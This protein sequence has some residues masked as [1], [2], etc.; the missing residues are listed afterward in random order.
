VTGARLIVS[1]QIAYRGTQALPS[2]GRG[3]V[4]LVTGVI[5]FVQDSGNTRQNK[6]E[7]SL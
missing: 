7:D 1:E 3:G 6:E 2:A 5:L 4:R